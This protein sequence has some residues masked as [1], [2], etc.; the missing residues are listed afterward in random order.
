MRWACVS[1]DM[2]AVLY[3]DGPK[4]H[5][6]QHHLYQRLME[7]NF[8]PELTL[9]SC[10]L[11]LDMSHQ[12][13]VKQQFV[14]I[15]ERS[16]YDDLGFQGYWNMNA[17]G[18]PIFRTKFAHPSVLADFSKLKINFEQGGGLYKFHIK[19]IGFDFTEKR[20]H[21]QINHAILFSGSTED[22]ERFIRARNKFM[23]IYRKLQ[24]PVPVYN[25]EN[26]E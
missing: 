2:N 4:S 21:G 16:N 3:S 18:G 15:L 9:K 7:H 26:H 6:T 25:F 11:S 1:K 20:W 5:R 14:T 22:K 13:F 12:I 8:L 24:E 23:P 10:R 19:N 17:V